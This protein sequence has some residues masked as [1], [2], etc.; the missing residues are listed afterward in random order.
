MYSTTSSQEN[1][2]ALIGLLTEALKATQSAM[3][4]EL[5]K[6]TV[7]QRRIA[8]AKN[9]LTGAATNLLASLE[10]GAPDLPALKKTR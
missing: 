4:N 9:L 2:K 5:I 7:H 3:G 10:H 1:L 6:G 8:N